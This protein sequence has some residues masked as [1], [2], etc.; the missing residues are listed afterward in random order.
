MSWYRLCLAICM[1]VVL[2]ACSNPAVTP[3]PPSTLIAVAPTATA[4]ATLPPTVTATVTFTPQP[5]LTATDTP[6]P[7][8]THTSTPTAT[9]TATPDPYKGY[10]IE[11][12]RTDTYGT[13]GD[14]KI[15]ETLEQTP[16]FTRYHIS[17]PSDGL[18]IDGFM[19]IPLGTGPFPVVLVNHGYMPTRDYDMLTYSAKYA[20]ALANNGFL[21]IHSSYRNHRGSE[22][23]P[24]PYRIGYARDIMN[25]IPMARRLPQ[26]DGKPVGLWGHSMGGGITLRVLT[27][28]DQVAAAVVYGSMSADET[29]NYDRIMMWAS[30]EPD[31]IARQER[32]MPIPPTDTAFYS[33]LSPINY[34]DL[35]TAPIAIHHGVLDDVVP[36]EWS[37]ALATR[38]NAAGKS[39]EFYAYEGQYHNFTGNGYTL[40]NQRA[41]DF[42]TR[43]MK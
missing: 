15:I 40:L 36:F 5:T 4:S 18:T 26:A 7:T 3:A 31:T 9:P 42:F 2:V 25:L 16:T 30:E 29:A 12:L 23:G 6:L 22:R 39:Y 41:A 37:E 21:T 13:E 32:Y 17:Y 10:S 8:V 19:D 20:D 34:L 35:I 24:N 11:S 28:T 43:Y 38:L 14:I 1:A 33:V 27:L